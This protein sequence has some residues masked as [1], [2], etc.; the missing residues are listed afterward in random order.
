M[1]KVERKEK[2]KETLK[3]KEHNFTFYPKKIFKEHERGPKN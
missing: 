2:A 3:N 1:T